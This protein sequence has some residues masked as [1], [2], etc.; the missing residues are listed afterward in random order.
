MVRV[1]AAL[2]FMVLLAVPL[3]H[4][5]VYDLQDL[6]CRSIT[7]DLPDKIADSISRNENIQAGYRQMQAAVNVDTIGKAS[8][9]LKSLLTIAVTEAI[10]KTKI[11]AAM[12]ASYLP[13]AKNYWQMLGWQTQAILAFIMAA[14]VILSLFRARLPFMSAGDDWEG[15]VSECDVKVRCIE[16]L[17]KKWGFSY[18]SERPCK[19]RQGHETYEGKIDFYLYD[20]NGP[21]TIIEDKATIKNDE[22]LRNARAQARSYCTGLYIFENIVVNSFV[23]ASKEGLRIY[24]I[25]RNEDGLVEEASPDKLNR[26]GRRWIKEKLLEIR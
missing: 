16:P 17:I 19:F 20:D 24:Q 22:D 25:R 10:N 9:D 15:C 13:L 6:N 4:Y 14:I 7:G 1:G 18:I 2:V 3:S 21:I 26:S 12:L 5:Y 8:K 11:A 23:I